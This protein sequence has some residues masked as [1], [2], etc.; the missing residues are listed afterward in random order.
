EFEISR[1]NHIPSGE[2]WNELDEVGKVFS[3]Y[4]WSGPAPAEINWRTVLPLSSATGA[5]VTTVRSARRSPDNTP[6][7]L[8]ELTAKGIHDGHDLFASIE[9]WFARAYDDVAATFERMVSPDV[10]ARW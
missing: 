8:F 10:K 2:A 5:V 9:H 1:V 7:F 6:V 3:D 4:T